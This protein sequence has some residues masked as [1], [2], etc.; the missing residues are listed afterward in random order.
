M[1]PATGRFF[2]LDDEL[3]LLPGPLTPR[4]HESAV[5]LGAWVPFPQA[6]AL[7]AHFTHTQVSEPT[8][9]RTTEQA[10]AAYVTVQTAEAAR[11]EREAPEPPL[12]PPLQQVSVDGAMVPLVGKGVWAEVKTLAIG[13]VQPP[14]QEAG[15]LVVHTTELS[16]FSR[17]TDHE[18]FTRLAL[19]ETHRRGVTSA[20]RVAGV[21]DGAVW[22]QAFLDYHRPDAVRILDWCHA[23]QYLAAV[24][25]AL[26]AGEAA[27][28]WLD[29]Q[30]R[31]LLEGEPEAVLGKLRGLRDEL[32]AQPGE[33]AQAK[34]AAVE[35]SLQYLET[36]R[37]QIRYAEFRAA[38][39]PI[40]SGSVESANKL[41]VEDRLKGAGMHWAPRHVDP[42][43]ALR[44]I[45]CNDRWDEAWPQICAQVRQQATDRAAARRA[46]RRAAT[47]VAQASPAGAAPAPLT[48]RVPRHQ[49]RVPPQP[50][51]HRPADNHPWRRY[52]RPLNPARRQATATVN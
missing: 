27:G 45:V 50:G 49:R 31:Q 5:R 44:N 51:P 30:L 41:V 32:A 25:A 10:G 34:R 4:L 24:A 3:G 28:Q 29:R 40:G 17:L 1:P 18:T 37:A 13:T 39:Y 52:G 20:G 35:T 26:F 8:L 23:A 48:P 47:A 9:R 11:V 16:Y 22:E 7:L 14:V 42:M 6:T 38:G 46:K 21:V 33:A 15:K 19:A 2:P 12:G 43:L 36:R